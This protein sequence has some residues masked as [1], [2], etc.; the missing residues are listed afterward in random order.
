MPAQREASMALTSSTGSPPPA[1]MR[2]KPLRVM[3][4]QPGSSCRITG[5]L[6]RKS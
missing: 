1:G 2:R 3:P 4:D 5:L 6:P